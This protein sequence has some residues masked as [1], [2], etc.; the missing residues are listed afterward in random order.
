MS[1]SP[2][3]ISETPQIPQQH[4]FIYMNPKIQEQVNKIIT[5]ESL[6]NYSPFNFQHV[7]HILRILYITV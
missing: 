1:I 2:L 3:K 5:H 4:S 6:I 7:M